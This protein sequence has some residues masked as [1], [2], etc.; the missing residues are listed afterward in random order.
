MAE[1]NNSSVDIMLNGLLESRKRDQI[2]SD[3]ERGILQN[4]LYRLLA[5]RLHRQS[6]IHR[7]SVADSGYVH[8]HGEFVGMQAAMAIGEPITSLTL[9]SFHHTSSGSRSIYGI[10]RI[11]Y[12]LERQ[13][14]DTFHHPHQNSEF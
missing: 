2:Q 9:D 10:N 8:I 3:A 12:I 1:N 6:V 4:P 14:L 11:Q 13:T 5:R 7:Q